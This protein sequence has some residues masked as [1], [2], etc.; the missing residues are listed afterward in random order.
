MKTE[1]YNPEGDPIRPKRY[2]VISS[3]QTIKVGDWITDQGIGVDATDA[4]GDRILGYCTAIVTPKKVSLESPS[5]TAGDYTGTWTAS[6]KSYA[7]SAT[8]DDAGG[9]GVM[10]EYVPAREG[11]RFKATLSAAKTTTVSSGIIEGYYCAASTSDGSLLDESTLS[12]SSTNTQFRVTDR[13]STGSTTE[14]I[15]E[16][17]LRETA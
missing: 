4:T 17:F 6:T 14:V 8:N 11:D 5:V 7:A 15:V 9:D 2:R 3:S 10:A 16:V 12:T 13:Y 1:L